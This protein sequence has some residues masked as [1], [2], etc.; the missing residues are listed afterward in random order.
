MTPKN[1]YNGLANPLA[2]AQADVAR[3]AAA[4]VPAD[5]AKRAA[6]FRALAAA[7]GREKTIRAGDG[8]T[9]ECDPALLESIFNSGMGEER[10]RV[11]LSIASGMSAADVA[12]LKATGL[13]DDEIRVFWPRGG[14]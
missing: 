10:E 8:C 12:K 11:V 1:V 9:W 6:H 4:P 5:T 13:T 7:I 14:K 3:L 2:V